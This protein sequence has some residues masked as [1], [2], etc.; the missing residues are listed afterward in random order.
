MYYGRNSGYQQPAADVYQPRFSMSKTRLTCAKCNKEFNVYDM[1]IYA[2]A[3]W[4]NGQKLFCC[5]YT[6]YR[7]LKNTIKDSDN[8][9]TES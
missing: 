2:Y 3:A 4:N 9:H 1:D 7:A 8:N 5:S 6:C